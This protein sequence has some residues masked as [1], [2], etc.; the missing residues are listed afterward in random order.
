MAVETV[1]PPGVEP[2]ADGQAVTDADEIRAGI[3]AR[4]EQRRSRRRHRDFVALALVVAAVITVVA[5]RATSSDNDRNRSASVNAGTQA[6]GTAP[7]TAPTTAATGGASEFE[8]SPGAVQW[9]DAPPDNPAPTPP[10][11]APPGTHPC[12]AFQMSA[13]GSW[14]PNGGALVGGVRFTNHSGTACSLH[15]VPEVRLVDGKGHRLSFAE[16]GSGAPDPGA[17]LMP[18][19]ANDAA[20]IG[21]QWTNWCGPL[22]QPVKVQINLPDKGNVINVDPDG[23]G[24]KGAPPCTNQ[25]AASTITVDPIQ[26]AAPPVAPPPS[27]GLVATIRSPASVVAGSTLRYEVTLKNPTSDPVPLQPCPSYSESV[28]TVSARYRLNCDPVG[29]IGPGAS[30]VFAIQLAVPADV[31]LGPANLQ[32]E[33]GGP[34]TSAGI[35]V[36]G[37]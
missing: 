4:R 13:K 24:F 12:T 31:P 26:T 36:T 22:S 37:S 21:V 19:G 15:G 25:G 27:A 9:I 32:W 14:Q 8:A 5:Y 28:A 33:A 23:D 7:P 18:P 34:A 1:E 35:T 30:V 2:A 17:V 29:Q 16:Q 3:R 11:T 6:P 20:A 10:A